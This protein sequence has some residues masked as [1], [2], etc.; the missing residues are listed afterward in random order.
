MGIWERDIVEA[1]Q[2]ATG[3]LRESIGKVDMLRMTWWGG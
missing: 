2:G 1:I 3:L